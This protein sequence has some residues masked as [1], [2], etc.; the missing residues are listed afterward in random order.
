LPLGRGGQSQ[1]A[2]APNQGHRDSLTH[3]TAPHDQDTFASEAGWQSA[4]RGLV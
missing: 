2:R 4:K 3:V 1:H